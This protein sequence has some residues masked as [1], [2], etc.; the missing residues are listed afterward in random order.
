VLEHPGLARYSGAI[1][2]AQRKPWT[3][4]PANRP[5]GIRPFQSALC[6]KNRAVTIFAIS[7][8]SSRLRNLKPT[9]LTSPRSIVSAIFALALLMI[10]RISPAPLL[11][12]IVFFSLL[13]LWYAF[14]DERWHV[15]RNCLVHR[16]GIG[17]WRYSRR[18]QDADLQIVARHNTDF[19]VPYYGLYAIANG[20]RHFLIERSEDELQQ[21]AKFISSHAGWPILP[22]TSPLLEY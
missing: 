8:T 13:A 16:T 4:T 15:E 18:F 17:R 7:M 20:R 6:R 9:D 22:E 11:G 19:N 14:G 2:R 3:A 10:G 21:L 1:L 12:L 5:N